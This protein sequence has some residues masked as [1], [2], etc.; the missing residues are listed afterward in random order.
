MHSI[1]NAV[2]VLP[3]ERHHSTVIGVFGECSDTRRAGVASR[4]GESATPSTEV[5]STP[6]L[7]T[8]ASNGVPAMI[9]WP[10]TA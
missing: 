6:F 5:P 4:Y 7:T 3:T 1:A 2:C 8:N 10:T 9:D